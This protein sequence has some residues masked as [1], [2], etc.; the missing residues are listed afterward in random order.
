MIFIIQG[1]HP[2][3]DGHHMF[4]IYGTLIIVIIYTHAISYLMKNQHGIKAGLGLTPSEEG[5]GK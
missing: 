4:Y 3:M 2:F 1:T 5:Q